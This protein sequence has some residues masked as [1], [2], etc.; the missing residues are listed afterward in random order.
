MHNN[1]SSAIYNSL[2]L[3]VQ[4]TLDTELAKFNLGWTF[5]VF[6]LK[7]GLSGQDEDRRLYKLLKAIR[8]EIVSADAIANKRLTKVK[9]SAILNRKTHLYDHRVSLTYQGGRPPMELINEA[10]E[11]AEARAAKAREARIIARANSQGYVADEEL[12]EQ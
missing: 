7:R 9:E 2:E 6:C 1:N 5:P 12:A 10:I 11:K 8:S 3:S 4:K